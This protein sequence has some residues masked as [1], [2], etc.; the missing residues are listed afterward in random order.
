MI[1][2]NTKIYCSFAKMAG[3]FGCNIFNKSFIYLN[4]NCIY[5]S[6]SVENIKK[7]LECVRVLDIKG[8]A[9]TMP[10]KIECL[11]Y[12]DEISEEV[13][14]IGSANTILNNGFLNAFNTDWY[15]AFCVLKEC[16]NKKVYILGDGGYAKAVLYAAL[17]LNLYCEKITRQNWN[18]IGDIKESI[19]YNCTPV[20]N[21]IIDK[22]NIFIDCNIKT[23]TGK[24]LALLQ[25]SK[26]FEMYTGLSFPID[27]FKDVQ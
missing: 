12:V 26:Q 5:K 11:K 4:L 10:Y 22:T 21:V 8:C 20:E 15:A 23:Y 24:K 17:K 19:V 27:I 25:A 16:N 14:E 7:A 1:D 13:K 9:V 3:N 2:K 18:D 6:F